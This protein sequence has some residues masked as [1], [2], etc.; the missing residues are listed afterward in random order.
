MIRGKL[1]GVGF[2]GALPHRNDEFIVSWCFDIRNNADK[3]RVRPLRENQYQF[4][5]KHSVNMHK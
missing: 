5:V 1:H 2:F 3:L 4:D